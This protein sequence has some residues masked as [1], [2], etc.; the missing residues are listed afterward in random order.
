MNGFWN[1]EART[2]WQSAFEAVQNLN[3]SA[4]FHS[5]SESEPSSSLNLSNSDVQPE[6]LAAEIHL[7]SL[8]VTYEVNGFKA[9]SNRFLV[10][11][12]CQVELSRRDQLIARTKFNLQKFQSSNFLGWKAF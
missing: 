6:L 11:F 2:S 9:L 1:T 8:I 10:L 12:R 7:F 4:E 5:L 3:R